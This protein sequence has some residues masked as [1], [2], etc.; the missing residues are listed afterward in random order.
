MG[1]LYDTIN[2]MMGFVV[3]QAEAPTQEA[4]P[5]E[6]EYVRDEFRRRGGIKNNIDS[7]KLA[8]EYRQA[9]QHPAFSGNYYQGKKQAPQ[10]E[11]QGMSIESAIK[12]MLHPGGGQVQAAEIQTAAPTPAPDAND[13]E[14]NTL[15]IFNKYQIPPAVAYGMRDAEGGNI[16]SNNAWNIN[17]TDSNPQ[18]A[19]NYDSPEAGA[20]AYARLIAKDPLYAKAYAARNNPDKMLEEIANAGYAGDPATWKQRS[21]STGGAGKHF[22]KYVDFIKG[23]NGY[24]RYRQQP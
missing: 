23:T 6:A 15:P 24:K 9:V 3:P 21:A 10:Q 20:E 19:Y 22:D 17:A 13:F 16:G 1:M 4:Y 5:G 2:K 18:G 12:G 8:Q 14:K 11:V 7:R